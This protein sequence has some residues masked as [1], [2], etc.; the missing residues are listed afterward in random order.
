MSK[1]FHFYGGV[2]PNESKISSGV[3]IAEPPLYPLYT[4]PLSMHIG[5]PAKALVSVGDKVLK[6]QR[7]GEPASFVSSNIHSPTSGKIKSMG[8]CLGPMGNQLPCVVIE[9]DGEDKEAEPLPPILNWRDSD[10]QTLRNRVAEAGIVGMG[11]ASFPTPVKLSVP[12]GKMIDTLIINGVECEPC[13]TADHRLM[14]EAP[15][16]IL[17]GVSIVANLLQVKNVFIGIED[18]KPD[19][20]AL[21]TKE[22]ASYSNPEIHIAPLHV[23]YPQGAEKQLI[24]AI[25][26]RQVPSGGLPADVHCVVQNIGSSFAIAE[27]VIKGKPLYERVTTVTGTP[28]V[29]PGNWRFRVGTSYA[30]AIKLAGGLKEGAQ[31]G[32]LISGGPMMGFAV[33]SQEIPVMKNT[34]GILLMSP[35]EIH[36]YTSKSC[37][38]CGRCNDVCP[39]QLMPGI[40]SVQ[41]ENERFDDAQNWHVMDCIECGCCAYTCPAGR[42]LVQHMRRAK[43][44]VGAKLRAAKAAADAAKAAADAAKAAADGKNA[45]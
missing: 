40:L 12:P 35:D 10:P 38:R 43:A 34:S 28:L 11:G 25:T 22:A 42:P 32:K 4:V 3:P 13:L 33:Y 23:R 9:S 31:I 37:L 44:E 1:F 39:M 29:A 15:K 6:G 21:L 18:N 7:I 17:D 24:Y 2:H 8:T 16:M 26:K 41:I 36:Q 27:A 14:L 5:A 30:E 45:K 20:I 19:A